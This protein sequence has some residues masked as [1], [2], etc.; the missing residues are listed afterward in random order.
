MRNFVAVSA[1]IAVGIAGA[2]AQNGTTAIRFN[3]IPS[4]SHY[5]KV[6]SLDSNGNCKLEP[7]SYS[8]TL[9]PLDEEVMITAHCCDASS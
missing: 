2:A 5:Q 4:S 8:A 9:A 1:A 6:T 7:Y 3:G